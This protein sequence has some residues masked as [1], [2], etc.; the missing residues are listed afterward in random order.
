MYYYYAT[1][2]QL[3]TQ[4]QSRARKTTLL[5]DEGCREV[6]RNG[7]K[8]EGTSTD[9]VGTIPQ[10]R[11]GRR[12]NAERVIRRPLKDPDFAGSQLYKTTG[13]AVTE[14]VFVSGCPSLSAR[15][16]KQTQEADWPTRFSARTS[17]SLGE[18]A[19]RRS[20]SRAS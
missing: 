2:H 7:T 8:S 17:L 13:P 20:S 14:P 10:L 19:I 11:K 16:L 3:K 15:E 5:N 4:P 9:V 18:D 12:P 1:L 6:D